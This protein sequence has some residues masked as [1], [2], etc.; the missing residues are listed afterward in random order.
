MTLTVRAADP[1]DIPA[2]AS[3]L[4]EMQAYYGAPV[5]MEEA[6]EAAGQLCTLP[7]EGF[8]PRTLLAIDSGSAIGSCVLNVML[9]AAELRR[10][11]YIRDLF[12]SARSRRRGVGRALVACAARLVREGGFCALDWTTDSQNLPARR[13][14]D[15]IGGRVLGRTYYRI[16]RN[17]LGALLEEEVPA[18]SRAAGGE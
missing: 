17:A 12:V 18:L 13:L 15:G 11:L 6:L 3:L 10:S 8:N 2:L 4:A 14:Y 5:P 9:P 7:P 1:A 16:E